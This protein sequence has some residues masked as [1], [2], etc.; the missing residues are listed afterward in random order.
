MGTMRYIV[1]DGQY[2]VEPVR[3]SER[4]D[5]YIS[6]ST[7]YQQLFRTGAS[8]SVKPPS[9]LPRRIPCVG[10]WPREHRCTMGQIEHDIYMYLCRVPSRM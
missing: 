2:R 3:E 5:T 4:A 1:V 6:R 7:C 9:F 8:Q 10:T